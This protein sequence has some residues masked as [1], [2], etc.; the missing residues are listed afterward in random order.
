[1]LCR[2]TSCLRGVAF[3]VQGGWTALMKAS[4]QGYA[5]VV[6]ALLDSGADKEAINHVRMGLIG[7]VPEHCMSMSG[8][9]F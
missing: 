9:V 3:L 6:Q 8:A 4:Q 1:M 2:W 7:P 5:E